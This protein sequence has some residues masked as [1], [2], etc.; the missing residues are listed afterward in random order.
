M[1]NIKYFADMFNGETLEFK[2]VDYVSNKDIRGYDPVS[3]AWVQC[4][5]KV[6]YKQYPSKHACDARCIYATGRIMKCE[7][8]CG[9]KNHGKGSITCLSGAA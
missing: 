2:K 5:R 9:G 1:A 8:S 4:T 6:E 3:N 7:C